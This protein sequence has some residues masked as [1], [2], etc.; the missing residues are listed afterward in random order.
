MSTKP[1]LSLFKIL[2]K[3]VP[4]LKHSLSSSSDASNGKLKWGS[5]SFN[6]S[7]REDCWSPDKHKFKLEGGRNGNINCDQGMW[8]WMRKNNKYN[9]VYLQPYP[10]NSLAV[11]L[12]HYESH[13]SR[14][15]YFHHCAAVTRC[16]C[17]DLPKCLVSNINP[18][19]S[20]IIK[21]FPEHKLGKAVYVKHMEYTVSG[22]TTS[23]CRRTWLTF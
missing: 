20:A 14:I 18:G 1:G 10:K 15:P 9:S 11:Q 21:E 4:S 2:H 16:S 3:T 6:H 7:T 8:K 17:W 12:L 13:L 23:K 5:I 22:D 19:H